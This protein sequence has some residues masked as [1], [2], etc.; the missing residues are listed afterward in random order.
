[1]ATRRRATGLVV[2]ATALVLAVAA[3][4]GGGGGGQSTKASGGGGGGSTGGGKLVKI[5]MTEFKFAPSKLTL[6]GSGTYTFQAKNAGTTQH[7]IE[8][9]GNGID[10]S[11]DVVGPGQTAT[12]TLQLKPGTYEFFCPVDSH[13][14][15]G[16]QGKLTV[17]G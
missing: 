10:K 17:S 14:E 1:M 11:S 16:M 12:L 13:R 8:I 15:N 7:A 6:N 3:C 4:G 2:L 9:D 5:S